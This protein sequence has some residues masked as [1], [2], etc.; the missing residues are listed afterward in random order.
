ML[1]SSII[2]DS[3]VGQL[4][5]IGV[6]GLLK[7]LVGMATHIPTTAYVPTDQTDPEV[8]SRERQSSVHAGV[9]NSS[10]HTAASLL[11]KTPSETNGLQMLLTASR[12]LTG[13]AAFS[14]SLG[15]F[16]QLE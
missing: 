5:C 6:L 7:V 4:H 9:S 16:A 14:S 12:F 15:S 2:P 1:T 8:L 10:Y 3:V 13:G 11:E